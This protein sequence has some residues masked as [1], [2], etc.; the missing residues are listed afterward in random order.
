MLVL[1]D[2]TVMSVGWNVGSSPVQ[3][4]AKQGILNADLANNVCIE[5]AQFELG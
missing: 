5:N 4:S 2:T 1:S 3:E